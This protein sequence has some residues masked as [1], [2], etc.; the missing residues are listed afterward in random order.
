MSGSPAAWN[1]PPTIEIHR[2]LIFLNVNPFNTN[3]SN[4]IAGLQAMINEENTTKMF[5]LSL[6]QNAS[7]EVHK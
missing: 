5:Q 2:P 3:I 4:D 7:D 1:P 6:I